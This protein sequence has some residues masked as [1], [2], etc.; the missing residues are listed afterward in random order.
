MAKVRAAGTMRAEFG[1]IGAVV[2]TG[3]F[4]GGTFVNSNILPDII[5]EQRL[6]RI[7]EQIGIEFLT[8]AHARMPANPVMS[9]RRRAR[10]LIRWIQLPVIHGVERRGEHHL[11]SVVEAINLLGFG[12]RLGEGGQ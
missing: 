11:L 1:R 8:A 7:Q 6:R 5:G 4:V 3:A 12:L 2:T 10:I 9:R